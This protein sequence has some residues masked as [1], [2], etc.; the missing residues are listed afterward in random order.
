MIHLSRISSYL[1][2]A[3]AVSFSALG[4]AEDVKLTGKPY[5]DMNYGPYLSASIEV[6]PGNIAYKGIAI[7]LDEGPGG[8]SKG[9]KFVVFETD[10]LR[11]AAAWSGDKF[12]DWRSIVYDGSHGTHPK[13]A[14]ERVFTNPV[15]PGWAKPGTDSFED[16]RLRGL[17][18]KPYGPLPRDW[19]QWQ[20]LGLHDNRV[21]LHYKIA[22]RHVLESPSYKESDGVGAVIRTMNFEERD[23]DIML[24]VV[25]GEGQ[26][27]VSTHDRISVAKF[28]SGLAVALSAE[29]GGA[30][31]VATDDGHLRLAIPSGGLL[32]LNL[33]IANGKA[34]ALAKLVGSLGQAE[35]LLETFQQGSGRRWTETIKTKPRRLGKPGA[36]VTEIITSPDKNPYRSW[37]RLGGFDFFEGGDRAAVCTWMG[38]VWIVEGINSDPQEFTWTRIAT[39]MFQPLGLKIVEG[40]IY[41]TCR[42][43]ITELVDAN[44]DGE[45]DYYRAF[46]HDAQ[47]T[48]HFHEFAMDL[49]TDA[50]GNFY[51]TKA[52]RHAKTALVPQHGT[53]IKVSPDG[54]SSEII[55]SGFRA[56]NGVCVNPDGTFYVSDQEGHWTPK[57]EINLIEKGK[58][59][60]NLMGYHKGLT[61][62]D[63]T[64]P[65]VWMHNDFDRSPAEQLWVDSD[66]WGGLGGH[67]L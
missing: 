66:K 10:T 46:N 7:R 59:Y 33:A 37:M 29:A 18:K 63:I 61:E 8:V 25:K 16:P 24:Q 35:N 56:P 6:G 27:K 30:K 53:L 9:N 52:A 60:G 4:Q 48:E 19:G 67:L 39:G 23:E 65:I 47:V 22:G 50:Y 42:D 28:D 49:Q 43:Q 62:A 57:N 31:F 13:L 2:F 58:F 32:A 41:V 26:A 11:M 14:G 55:A 36:F 38:D 34:E 17:D 15:A 5:I 40:K 20:G 54:Q 1:T 12:I 3:A 44:D 51:Y 21:I 45:T 64:S